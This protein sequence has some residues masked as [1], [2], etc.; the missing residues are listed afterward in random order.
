METI[1][2]QINTIQAFTTNGRALIFYRI[3]VVTLSSD[4]IYYKYLAIIR[5]FACVIFSQ[6]VVPT[7]RLLK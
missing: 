2:F 7:I 4:S 1:T 3:I 5:L 6:P